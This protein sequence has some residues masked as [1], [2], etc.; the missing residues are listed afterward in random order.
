MIEYSHC[1]IVYS[2]LTIYLLPLIVVYLSSPLS[3]SDTYD[4]QTK[5]ANFKMKTHFTYICDNQQKMCNFK[6][7][8]LVAGGC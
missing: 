3:L 7:A 1:E 4:K 5:I 6:C 8:I 2:Q